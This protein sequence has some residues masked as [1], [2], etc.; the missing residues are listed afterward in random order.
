MTALLPLPKDDVHVWQARVDAESL[1]ECELLG[2]L[3]P[4]E[5]AR[6]DRFHFRKD[7]DLYLVGRSMMRALLGGYVGCQPS[8]VRICY[9]PYGKPGLHPDLQMDLQFNLSHSRELALLAVTRGSPIGVDV[10]F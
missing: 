1:Q 8:E 9:S 6:A 4:D 3:S 5:R 10:E 7:R 2:A